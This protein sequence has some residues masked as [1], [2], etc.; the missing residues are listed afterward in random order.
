M[1]ELSRR[2]AVVTG[3]A[4]GIGLALAR[5]FADD[6]MKL[7]LADVEAAPLEQV[8]AELAAQGSE[9]IALRT[10]VRR[11]ADLAALADAAYA[12]YGAVHLLCNNAG[13]AMPGVMAPVWTHA[14]EDWR[15]VMD[16]NLVGVLN[17]LRAFVPRMLEGG[18][19]GHVL[20]T[21]SVAGLLTGA[22]PYNVSK[23][24]VVC[25]TE[26][27]YKDLRQL[28]ARISAS[29]LCPGVIDTAIMQAQRN[30]PGDYGPA[31]DDAALPE[32]V[33][34]ALA[35]VQLALKAGYPPE[36]VAQA[37]ADG[38]R[39]DRFYIVPAQE[40]LQTMNDLRM[41]DILARRNPTPVQGPLAAKPVGA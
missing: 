34:Q 19:E 37:A 33:R 2:V 9:A 39:E 24:G 14:H 4:S 28:G 35:Q 16:V 22:N 31:N 36:Q 25:I 18:D 15:W 26:G 23:H 40:R 12:A 6:G 1:K 21:A 17:G 10:D 8:R 38:I 32:S 7:V 20:N 11:E 13:V 29:V 30:R 41:H 3:A 27:L 5:R